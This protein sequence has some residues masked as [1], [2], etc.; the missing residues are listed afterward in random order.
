MPF[1]TVS[2]FSQGMGVLD[3]VVIIEGMWQFLGGK[4]EVIHCNQ[5]GTLLLNCAKVCDPIDLLFG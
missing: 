3:R 1:G 5:R 2:G 4:Y